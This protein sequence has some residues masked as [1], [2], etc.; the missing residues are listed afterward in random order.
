[1]VKHGTFDLTF[2]LTGEVSGRSRDWGVGDWGSVPG[3]FEDIRSSPSHSASAF[4]SCTES[5]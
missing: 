4:Y 1:M 3:E 2:Y 5:V